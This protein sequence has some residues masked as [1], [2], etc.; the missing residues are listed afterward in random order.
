MTDKDDIEI[1]WQELK[2]CLPIGH[3]FYGEAQY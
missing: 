1:Q 3:K 2:N